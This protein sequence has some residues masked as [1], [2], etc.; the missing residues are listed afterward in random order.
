MISFPHA[1]RE[2]RCRSDPDDY[3]P[4]QSRNDRSAAGGTSPIVKTTTYRASEGELPFAAP[5]GR[6]RLGADLTDGK[7]GFAT[8]ELTD[9]GAELF[10]ASSWNS[11][12]SS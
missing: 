6:Q 2:Q 10:L 7:G 4:N 1:V 8:I 9:D 12:R 5:P 11:M 3:A